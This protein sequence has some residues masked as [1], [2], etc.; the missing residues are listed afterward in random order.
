MTR[1]YKKSG[2]GISFHQGKYARA[3]VVEQLGLLNDRRQAC[4]GAR[5]RNGLFM[6]AEQYASRGMVRMAAEVR[7]EAE[8]L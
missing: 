8:D 1:H 4:L 7:A 5:D 3:D 6:V 2:E